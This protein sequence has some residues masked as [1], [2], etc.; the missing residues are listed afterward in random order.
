MNPI[1]AAAAV[2]GALFWGATLYLALRLVRTAGGSSATRARIDT[3]MG[4]LAQLENSVA[5]TRAEIARLSERERI[6]TTLRQH[7]SAADRAGA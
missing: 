3:L 6:L 4:R 2:L 7:R 1:F 5:A